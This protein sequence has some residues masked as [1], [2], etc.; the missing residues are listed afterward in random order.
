MADE[1]YDGAIGIDLGTS[2]KSPAATRNR[3]LPQPEV[4]M[5]TFVCAGTTYSCGM[6]DRITWRV[7]WN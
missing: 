2:F 3:D 7:Q 1:V 6:F 4:E 5:L